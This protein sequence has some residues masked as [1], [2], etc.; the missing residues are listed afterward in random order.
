M[1]LKLAAIVLTFLFSCVTA[2]TTVFAAEKMKQTSTKK[3]QT[4]KIKTNTRKKS[5]FD[6]AEFLKKKQSHDVNTSVA[7]QEVA[8][9]VIIGDGL[10]CNPA[11]KQR[12][13]CTGPDC[14]QEEVIT[15]QQLDATTTESLIN[16]NTRLTKEVLKT[17]KENCAP[18]QDSQ[19]YVKPVFEVGI[20]EPEPGTSTKKEIVPRVGI[21]ATF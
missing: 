11:K 21:R 9:G 13:F 15:D 10:I 7:E 6:P 19:P 1:P 14:K 18:V 16:D 12:E 20:K 17:I 4:K 5:A 3:K 8:T 2:E